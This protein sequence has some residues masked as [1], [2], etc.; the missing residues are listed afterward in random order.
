MV[1]KF[2]APMARDMRKN[3]SMM[4]MPCVAII[5]RAST[6]PISQFGAKSASPFSSKAYRGTGKIAVRIL[7][8]INH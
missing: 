1:T 7:V 2:L 4:D 6:M 5:D 3:N 8:K